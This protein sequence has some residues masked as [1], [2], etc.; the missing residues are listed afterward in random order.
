VTRVRPTTLAFAVSAALVVVI[1]AL[2]TLERGDAAMRPDPARFS[3]SRVVQRL[4]SLLASPRIG[5]SVSAAIIRDETAASFYDSPAMLDS[6]IDAWRDALAAAGIDTRVLT[7]AAARGDRTARVFVVPSSPCLSIATH[8]ALE[9]ATN[10]GLGVILT[11]SS[12]TYD[13]ACRSLGYGVI[14]GATGASRAEVLDAREMTYVTFPSGGPLSA[15]IPPGARLDLNPGGQ[16]ALRHP[17]RDAFYS[18]YALQPEPARQEALLDAAVTHAML[19]RGRVV[20]WGFELRDVVPRPW[21]RAIARLLV[22]NS[23]AWVAGQP[24]ASVEPWQRG[25]LAAASIAQD[26]E[27]GFGNARHALDSLRAARAPSTF[28]LTSELAQRFERLSRRMAEFGEIGTHSENHRLLGGLPADVQRQRLTTTQREL[29]S[30]IGKP[31]PGLRPPEEQFDAATLSGWLEAGGRYLFGANDSRAAAPELLAFGNDTLVLVGR[32]GSDDFAAAATR[33][34]T[35]EHLTSVF[36]DEYERVRALGGHYVLSYHSQLLAR[37][38][39]VPVLAAVAR[40]LVADTAVWLAT[41]GDIADW[42]RARAGLEARAQLMGERMSVVVRNRGSRLVR[43]A[44][45]RISLPEAKRARSADTR[46]LP[47]DDSATVRLFLP[48]VPAR[49]TR[50]FTVSFSQSADA[51]RVVQPR[52]PPPRRGFF[53]WWPW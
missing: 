50:T 29:T 25:K 49:T 38:E 16:V 46:L 2:L 4:P 39:L 33:A 47:P 14:V 11:G 51:K 48:P 30:L 15:D 44:V 36:L 20:Y 42:W 6:I 13:A 23:V 45:V 40:R 27:T 52:R 28:F 8:E 31:V 22:R 26:V 10:R 32:I 35:T 3:G 9:S 43:G 53:R 18:D 1:S 41:T 12:G 34:P 5:A 24:I 19:G 37:P 7:P 17:T 21:D